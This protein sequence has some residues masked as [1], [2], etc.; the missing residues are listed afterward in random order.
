V[1]AQLRREELRAL[2]EVFLVHGPGGVDFPGACPYFFRIRLALNRKLLFFLASP[3]RPEPIP[4]LR[5]W[6]ELKV[7]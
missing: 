7:A 6:S 1:L 2:G 4:G 3:R 5:F